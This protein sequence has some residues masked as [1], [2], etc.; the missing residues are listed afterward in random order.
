[1]AGNAGDFSARLIQFVGSAANA[2]QIRITAAGKVQLLD[3]GGAQAGITTNSVNASGLFRLEWHIV[4]STTVGQMEVKLFNSPASTTATETVTT[5][6]NRN[7]LASADTV[8]IGLVGGSGV[9]QTLWHDELVA[10]ATSYPGPAGAASQFARP[11]AD[12][13]TA[14]WTRGGTDSGTLWGQLD[15]A[16]ADDADYITSTAL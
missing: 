12:N 9:T 10:G 15:E 13:A 2:C 1:M 4:H 7:L 6:A 16:T 3:Q 11:D 8:N 5:A 14:G